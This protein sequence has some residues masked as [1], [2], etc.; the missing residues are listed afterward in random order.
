MSFHKNSVTLLGYYGGDK[1]ICNSAWQST[2]LAVSE[3]PMGLDQYDIDKR[4]D[5][6]FEA[7]VHHKKKSP[8][9]LIQMLAEHGHHSPFEKGILHFQVRGDISVHV[10]ML[11]HRIASANSESARYKELKDKWY[12]PNDWYGIAVNQAHSFGNSLANQWLRDSEFAD[13]SDVLENFSQLAHQLYHLACKDLTPELGR[14]RTKESAR[15]FLPYAK[16]LDF[17]FMINFRSFMNFQKLRN[18]PAAQKEIREISL[19]ML[20]QVAEIPGAPFKDSLTAFG[21]S[22][23]KIQELLAS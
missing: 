20:R 19:E 4:N 3:L 9:E 18:S 7:T 5:L 1:E 6:I 8:S 14:K 13:W 17:D 2:E 21:Y 12:I 10:Q 22:Q 16:Q 23:S 15:F 11:K